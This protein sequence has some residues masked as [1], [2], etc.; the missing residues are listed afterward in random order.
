MTDLPTGYQRVPL[1]QS[2]VRANARRYE[3]ERRARRAALDAVVLAV[4]LVIA[5]GSRMNG[6]G[7]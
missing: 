7:S 4:V 2:P 6:D 3:Q 1:E 5:A